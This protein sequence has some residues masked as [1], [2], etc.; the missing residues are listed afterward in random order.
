MKTILKYFSMFS[1]I[2]GFGYGIENAFKEKHRAVNKIDKH[3]KQSK[4]CKC[5]GYSEIDRYAKQILR[6]HYP[7]RKNCGDARRIIPHEIPDFDLL[8]GGFP[9]QS[10]SIAGKRK[11][12]E[13]TRGTLFFEIARVLRDKKPENFILENVRGLLSAGITDE[14]GKIIK[15]T[16]GFVFKIIIATL[17]ELGY[18][19][20]EWQILNSKYFGVPQNRERIFIVG[21]LTKESGHQVFPIGNSNKE[22]IQ[23]KHERTIRGTISTKNQSPQNQF[24]GSSTLIISKEVNPKSSYPITASYG[25]GKYGKGRG[26]LIQEGYINNNAVGHSRDAK[27]KTVSNH[28]KNQVQALNSTSGTTSNTSDLVLDSTN[29]RRLTPIECELLQGFSPD[30]TKYGIDESGN[31]VLISDS[32]RY[33][34]LGNAVTTNVVEEIVK[35]LYGL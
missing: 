25:K 31:K 9:C 7:K 30:Y 17:R 34:V 1:G 5:I 12:L 4:S 22:I 3:K 19:F 35:R 29:I 20:I 2:E 32:Q 6:Y 14:N 18:E 8:V 21:H 28:L 27:G 23:E 10:F 16:S 33:K 24:D 11:G 26:T 13:D 15:G